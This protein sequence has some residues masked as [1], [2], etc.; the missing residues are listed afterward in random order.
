MFAHLRICADVSVQTYAIFHS[1]L[2]I[3]GMVI[4]MKLRTGC[5]HDR[6]QTFPAVRKVI[7]EFHENAI[8]LSAFLL[9]A[10]NT[11]VLILQYR[12]GLNLTENLFEN[13]LTFPQNVLRSAG[14]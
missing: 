12:F 4:I 14:F 1:Y 5:T 3:T 8:V 9:P 10:T 2:G 6:K 13:A 11:S 7:V